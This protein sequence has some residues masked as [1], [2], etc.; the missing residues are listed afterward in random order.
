MRRRIYLSFTCL[1]VMVLAAPVPVFSSPVPASSATHPL[2]PDG[3]IPW[4]GQGYEGLKTWLSM[5][6]APQTGVAD[7]TRRTTTAQSESSDDSTDTLQ[8]TT[9]ELETC[10]DLGPQVDPDG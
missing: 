2:T 3:V 10:N 4:I 9:C 6:H 1:A 7:S 5:L 8:T